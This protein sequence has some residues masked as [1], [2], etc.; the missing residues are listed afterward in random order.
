MNDVVAV[1]T[2][3]PKNRRI[4]ELKLANKQFRFKCKRCAALCCKLGG[5]V[6]TR[7]DAKQIAAVGYPVNDFFEPKKLRCRK[8]ATHGWR[9]KN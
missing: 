5:P 1:I 4:T 3:D 2:F 9:P 6:L 8:F 7:K